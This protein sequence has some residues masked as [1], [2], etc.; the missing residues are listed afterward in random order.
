[1]KIIQSL[2]TE[3][4]INEDLGYVPDQIKDRV[5]AESWY[6]SCKGYENI[7]AEDIKGKAGKPLL[8]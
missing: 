6:T 7:K 3:F 1:M 8:D 4:R 2:K 5:N